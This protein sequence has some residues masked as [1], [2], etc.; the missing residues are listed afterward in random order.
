MC[1]D[2]RFL[3]IWHDEIV[4]PAFNKAWEDS[5]L[6]ELRGWSKGRK[7]KLGVGQGVTHEKMAWTF[8]RVKTALKQ[9]WKKAAVEEWP[10]WDEGV[11]GAD[12]LRT[13]VMQRAWDSIVGELTEEKGIGMFKDAVLLGVG[14]QLIHFGDI[15]LARIQGTVA[16]EW[17][18]VV[19]ARFVVPGSFKVVLRSVTGEPLPLEE[20]EEPETME[21]YARKELEDRETEKNALETEERI[22]QKLA[23]REK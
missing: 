22:R 19:D 6:V 20:G 2:M 5:G 13:G 14:R 15:G 21:E 18:R 12:E 10:A 1:A 7:M 4:R 3:R 16:E 9:G 17:D 23:S 11:E 8:E